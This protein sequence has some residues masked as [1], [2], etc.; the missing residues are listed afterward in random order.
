MIDLSSQQTNYLF[1][2]CSIVSTQQLLFSGL[3]PDGDQVAIIGPKRDFINPEVF[4]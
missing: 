4:I 1:K 2:L 3:A